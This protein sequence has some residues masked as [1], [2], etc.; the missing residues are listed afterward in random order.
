MRGNFEVIR[1]EYG[2][3]MAA[4]EFDYLGGHKSIKSILM[5]ADIKLYENGLLIKS[6][7][8][9]DYVY[10]KWIEII[11]INYVLGSR[12]SFEIEYSKGKIVLEKA[13][14]NINMEEFLECA[15]KLSPDIK[16]E[17]EKDNNNSNFSCDITEDKILEFDE[18]DKRIE[19]ILEGI[20]EDD[21]IEAMATWM[22]YL[23]KH[24]K[25]PFEAEISEYQ[26]GGPLKAGYKLQ[27]KRIEEEL[28]P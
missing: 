23:K 11:R 8:S 14:E 19:K 18:Q 26:E 2:K 27:V 21:D 4:F 1:S 9:C 22:K 17:R 16:I 3:E 10:L 15:S 25:F 28:V 13:K 7:L 5:N 24:L 6:G 20:D 12:E